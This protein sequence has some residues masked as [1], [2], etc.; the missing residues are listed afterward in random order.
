LG[1]PNFIQR[2]LWAKFF[3]PSKT[4]HQ[5]PSFS[6]PPSVFKKGFGKPK[7]DTKKAMVKVFPLFQ[8]IHQQ[9][10]F[11]HSAQIVF[12]EGLSSPNCYKEGFG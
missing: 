7:F 11:F 4:I 6:H 9:P 12:K 2:R 1:S 8:T 10:S 5:Q 3:I